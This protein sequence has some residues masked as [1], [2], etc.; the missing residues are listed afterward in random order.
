MLL[1]IDN[2]DSF[3]YNLY[4][5]FCELGAQVK[6]VRNDEIDLDGIRALAP[7][8]LVISPGPCTPNEA[9]I[10]LAAIEAF[11]GQLPIL[12]V[13]LGHQAI[14]Q[15]FGGQVVRARQVM[16]GKT[17]P[18]RHTGQGLFSGLNNPLTVTRYHS[19]VVKN[20]TLPECFELTAW[21]EL[22]DGSIDE[23]MG[24]QHKTLALEAVQFHPES[25]K[26]EQG[27]Q[28]LA[29]FLNRA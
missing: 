4:Q 13:C 3:T 14:A 11:A 20:G 17:S 28:L 6:V 7:T 18:I 25:I 26:T 8:H 22:N 2:Y 23:I 10:S 16:H 27:H 9:G 24:F 29:N 5:Y 12:G 1:M 15:A 19:L 21:T